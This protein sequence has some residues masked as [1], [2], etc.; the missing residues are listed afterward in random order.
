VEAHCEG[1]HAENWDIQGLLTYLRTYFPVAEGETIPEDTLRKGKQA[2]VDLLSDAAERA[3]EQKEQQVGDNDQYRLIERWVMLETIDQKWVDYL[4]SMEHFREGVGLQAYGQRDPLVEYKNT[5]FEMFNDLTA[6]I[7]ADIVSRMYHLQF[8]R[9]DQP[10][11]SR[12]PVGARTG[13]GHAANG[14]QAVQG[15]PVGAGAAAGKIGRNDPCWCGS[16]RKYKRCH[17]R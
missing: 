2:V 16:G 13:N 17:G 1:R 6:S 12:Q 8:V 14:A 11:P 3:Y 4:T 7:Q 10:P 5:A 9:E 15:D